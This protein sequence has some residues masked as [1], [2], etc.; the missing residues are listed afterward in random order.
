MSEEYQDLHKNKTWTLIPLNDHMKI[1]GSKWVFKV[2]IILM[3][4]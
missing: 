2:N 3:G 4:A 1:E